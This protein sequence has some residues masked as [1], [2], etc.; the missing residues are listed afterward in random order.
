MLLAVLQGGILGW[1]W[2]RR[3]ALLVTDSQWHYW[4]RNTVRD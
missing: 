2:T 3:E 4:V 1:L